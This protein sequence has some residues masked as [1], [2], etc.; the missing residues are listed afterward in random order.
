M[1]GLTNALK[2]YIHDRTNN[3]PLWQKL[4]FRVIFNDCQIPGEG[5]HKI[6]D[7]IRAQRA[8]PEYDPNY[9]HMLY[10]ADADLIHLGLATHETHF[11]ILR[12]VVMPKQEKKKDPWEQF[13]EDSEEEDEE[14]ESVRTTLYVFNIYSVNV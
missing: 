11:N 1:Q 6:L 12:E 5:E 8:Q 3:D 10:G 4:K 9:R 13:Q 7:F 14:E 2:Y